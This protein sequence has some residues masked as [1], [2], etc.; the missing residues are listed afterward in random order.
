VFD[1]VPVEKIGY[2]RHNSP[3]PT[4]RSFNKLRNIVVPL[5]LFPRNGIPTFLPK[6]ILTMEIICTDCQSLLVNDWFMRLGNGRSE[7][8]SSSQIDR[9]LQTYNIWQ[10]RKNLNRPS[11][12]LGVCCQKWTS[13]MGSTSY[14]ITRH[15]Q[16]GLPCN[17][18][19]V[20]ILPNPTR[21]RPHTKPP[22]GVQIDA[23]RGTAA[24]QPFPEE[25]F[26]LR[27]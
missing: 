4:L 21:I 16:A 24:R 7:R 12:Q 3:D 25:E 5:E 17:E 15:Y 1:P 18:I 23:I 14:A 11:I 27:V 2:L 10:I 9:Y 19:Q 20:R 22:K 8:S 13:C 26:H 6:S